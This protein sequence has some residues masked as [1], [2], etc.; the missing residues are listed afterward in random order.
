MTPCQDPANIAP[1]R[2]IGIARTEDLPKTK[3][4]VRSRNYRRRPCPHC[5]HSAYRDRLARRTLHDLGNT[6]TGRPRDIVL[7]YSQHYCRRC[8]KYFNADSTDLADPGSHY[9]RRV[10]DLAVRLVVEDGLPYRSAEWALWRDHRVFVPYA[11]IQN[12]VEAGGKRR[13][14]GSTPSISTGPC[15]TSRAIIAADELYD[16]PFCILSIVDNRT[17]KRLTYQVLDHDPT[18]KD[19][20][21][22]FRRFHAALDGP[23]ADPPGDHD[24][25]LGAVSRADRRGLRRGPAPGLHLPRPSRGDQGGPLGRGP[26]AQAAGGHG[27]EAA[28]GPASC[29]QG[30][31][32]CGPAQEADRAEGRRAVRPPLPVRPAASESPPSGRRLRRITR[33]SPQLRRLRELMEEVY[34]LFDRR[35]R[36][37]TALAKLAALR[38]RLRRFGRLRTVLK[39]LLSPGLEKALVFLDERLMGATSNAVERGNRRYRKMQKTVYRVRTQRAIEGRLALDLL[40]ESQAQGRAGTTEGPAQG[41]SGMISLPGFLDL[42]TSLLLELAWSSYPTRPSTS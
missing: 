38:A 30:R 39:K 25:R 34:R 41:Q 22:F 5:G 23:R 37:A 11:T 31:P 21:A 33:G 17:F 7:L 32:A 14:D 26:G 8:R 13:R 9:T 1:I 28:A 27:A 29:H 12:W 19:I 16:G 20:T 4:S 6:L 24:R 2:P 36:M 10:V 40:R 15:P 3:V 18:H 42:L 35:C